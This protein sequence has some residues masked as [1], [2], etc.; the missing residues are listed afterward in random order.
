MAHFESFFLDKIHKHFELVSKQHE[1][2]LM[3][4]ER[5]KL[6]QRPYTQLL[7]VAL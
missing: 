2:T 5:L 3:K 1:S 4:D 7:Y 6:M